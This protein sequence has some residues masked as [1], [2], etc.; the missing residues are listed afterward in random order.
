MSAALATMGLAPG[1]LLLLLGWGTLVGLDL[2][3]WPQLLLARP[4]VA[5]TVAGLLLG[6]VEAGLRVGLLLELFALDV[7]AVGAV[8]YPDYGPATVGAVVLAAFAPWETG[9]GLATALALPVAAVGGWTMQWVRHANARALQRA[10]DALAAGDP[11]AVRRLQ[12]GGLARD[13]LRA[14]GLTALALV[15]AIAARTWVQPDPAT[16]R[17]LTLAAVGA[18]L[19]AVANGALRIAGRGP[20]LGWLAAGLGLGLVL[21]A[22]LAGVLAGGLA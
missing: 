18:A 11:R 6:D 17:L 21:A 2:V 1:V 9:L 13:A 7:L 15:L 16:G 22:V 12:A 8:R 14:L 19:A 5:G 20:R 3:S 4:L 10:T